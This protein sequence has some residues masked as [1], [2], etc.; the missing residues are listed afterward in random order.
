M[1]DRDIV[2]MFLN[3][4]LIEEVRHL[5]GMDISNV[6]TKEYWER[7]CLGGWE[8]WEEK[9]MVFIDFTYYAFQAVTWNKTI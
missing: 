4:I 2:D 8:I 1:A 7:G 3:I 5:C 9:M 6:R